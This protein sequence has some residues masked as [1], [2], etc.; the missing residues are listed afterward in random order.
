MGSYKLILAGAILCLL[1]ASTPL[2]LFGIFNLRG[3]T[4]SVQHHQSTIKNYDLN[5]SNVMTFGEIA[6]ADSLANI[7]GGWDWFANFSFFNSDDF[8][9]LP[10]FCFLIIFISFW[11]ILNRCHMV[12]FATGF[13]VY[14]I[15]MGGA[16]PFYHFLFN[17][18]FFFK[19]FRNLYF[20]TI[21]L[22]PLTIVFA[23]LLLKTVV[24][25]WS[26]SVNKMMPLIV[27]SLGHLT[28]FLLLRHYGCRFYVSYLTVFLSFLFFVSLILGAFKQHWR[29]MLGC[30]FCL[31]I[32]EPWCLFNYYQ[33]CFP[34]YTDFPLPKSHDMPR[35]NYLRP[36]HDELNP[37]FGPSFYSVF[38]F[39][40]SF[41]DASG[42]D[43]LQ[44]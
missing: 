3:D 39:L 26:S 14:L 40:A 23:V 25:Q 32:L 41:K 34:N 22:L 2:L 10:S 20:F 8:S 5:S 11:T 35:F 12:V 42:N 38:P 16:T 37:R 6:Y 21:Y 28:F 13:L 9:F 31:I 7:Y 36:S 19:Y 1:I 18:L 30:L 17:H 15:G 29:F 27:T 24:E 33:M 4:V 44:P 43:V